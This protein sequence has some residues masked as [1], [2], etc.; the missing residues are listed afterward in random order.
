MKRLSVLLLLSA[1]ALFAHVVVLTW[2]YGS[3]VT[4]T[5][6]NIYRA[7]SACSTAP[8]ATTP[9]ALGWVA[10]SKGNLGITHFI[11]SSVVSGDSYCY[12]VTAGIPDSS[13]SVPSN[14]SGATIPTGIVSIAAPH[15][16][17]ATEQ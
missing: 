11:D 4:G 1:H 6:F 9:M 14:L 16:L 7:N 17:L 13:E 10:I 2:G 5:F 8:P 3:S 12:Y 15:S